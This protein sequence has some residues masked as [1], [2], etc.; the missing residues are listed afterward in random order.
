MSRRAVAAVSLG[1]IAAALALAGCDKD[2]SRQDKDKTWHA[3]QELPNGL[4]WPLTPPEGMVTRE[5]PTPPPA[6]SLALL[7]RGRE[8]YEIA[9]APCHGATGEGDGM[10]VER[11]FPA[12]P[13]LTDK[14]IA[15]APTQH[16]VDV[17]T[18]GY[19]VMYSFAERVAPR[20]R[21]AIAAYIRALQRARAATLAEVPAVQRSALQ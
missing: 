1:V 14:R 8:R 9:C 18:N 3:A 19:G 12:P 16:Y 11:G 15:A 6:L 7:Q 21:W 13:P 2:M 10:I 4:E 17:I 20:D 5:A